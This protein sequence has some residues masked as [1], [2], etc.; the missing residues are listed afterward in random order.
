MSLEINIDVDV[1]S[2]K[3]FNK[4]D[5]LTIITCFVLDFDNSDNILKVFNESLVK[6]LNEIR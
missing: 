3:G 6:D 4:G 5:I 1:D 2:A